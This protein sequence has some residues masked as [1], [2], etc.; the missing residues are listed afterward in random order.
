[1]LYLNFIYVER[2]AELD[3]V[4]CLRNVVFEFKVF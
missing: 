4:F 3:L 2:N 1:M